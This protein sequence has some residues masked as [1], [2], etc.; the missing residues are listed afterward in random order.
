MTVLYI[1]LSTAKGDLDHFQF[2]TIIKDAAVNILYVSFTEH[3]HTFLLD[4]YLRVQ[5]LD[6]MTCICSAFIDLSKQFS[7]GFFN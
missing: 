6:R 2:P 4:L 3:M 7:K 5:L 1:I